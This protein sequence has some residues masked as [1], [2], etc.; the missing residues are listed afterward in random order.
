MN[1]SLN[2]YE[3]ETFLYHSKR[4]DK[5]E[6]KLSRIEEKLDRVLALQIGKQ[7]PQGNEYENE[8]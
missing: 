3:N 1:R 6:T 4:E 8:E 5:L 7:R 2:N